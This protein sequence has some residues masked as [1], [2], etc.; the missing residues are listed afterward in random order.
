MQ[1]KNASIPNALA[2]QT[3]KDFGNA[4]S[5]ASGSKNAVFWKRVSNCRQSGLYLMPSVKRIVRQYA[6]ESAS[7][8]ILTIIAIAFITA[9]SC[10]W[11]SLLVRF[12]P[13]YREKDAEENTQDEDVHVEK[14][15]EKEENV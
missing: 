11:D 6:T 2:K 14:D 12:L 10:A 3:K 7:K 5:V 4:S 9:F 13:L 1:C 15:P 8:W